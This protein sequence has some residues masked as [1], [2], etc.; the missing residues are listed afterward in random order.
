MSTG[1]LENLCKELAQQCVRDIA[2][3]EAPFFDSVWCVLHERMFPRGEALS[4]EHWQIGASRA[5]VV[6]ELGLHGGEDLQ[7]VSIVSTLSAL[8]VKM[9]S[10][11]SRSKKTLDE[12]AAKYSDEFGTPKWAVSHIKA[13]VQRR[14]RELPT[15]VIRKKTS[16]KPY[17]I[18]ESGK[19]PDEGTE[20]DVNRLREAARRGEFDIFANDAEGGELLVFG[21]PSA[22]KVG[23]T[24]AWA[25]LM[26][27]LERVGSRWTREELFKKIQPNIEYKADVHSV[28]AYQW[29]RHVKNVLDEDIVKSGRRG[30]KGL[31]H[32]WFQTKWRKRVD[33]SRNLRACLIRRN[34]SADI[35]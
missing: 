27:L 29:T 3:A 22:L 5:E 11:G 7:T 34:P 21:K 6:S 16:A 30:T 2:P 18:W 32:S 15:K 10:S 28:L 1:N 14:I 4:P 12:L 20:K 33:I 17:L 31:V 19:R 35:H 8:M 26:A 24:F 13:L 9:V 25:T 23:E